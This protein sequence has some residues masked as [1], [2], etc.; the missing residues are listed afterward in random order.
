MLARWRDRDVVG[1]D[2]TAPQGRRAVG[3]LRGPAHGQ[4]PPRPPPRVGPRV[5]GPLPPLPDH[6][7][8]ATSPARAAGTA[9]G[10]RSRS[11]SR[12]SSGF[13]AKHEIEAYGIAEFNQRCRD[14]VQ[15]YVE[16]WAALTER[17]GMWI[18]TD[19]RLLDAV[20][21]T[22][23]NRSG[24]SSA[25]CGTRASLYEGHKVVALLRRAAAP[26]CR[27]TSSASQG[28]Q[29]VT[30]PSVYVRF[31]VVAGGPRRRPPRV[32]DHAVDAASP[33]SPPRSGPT[34][35]TCASAA[36]DGGRDLVLAEA[37]VERLLRR[38]PARSSRGSPAPTSSAGTTS[39]RST[40]LPLDDAGER[41]VA[42]DFVTTD[43]GSGIVHLAPA[44][45]EDD[46]EVGRRRG[47]PGAQP[48]RRRR[49]ASTRPV[50]PL[51]R[52]VREGRRPR[53][54]STTSPRAACSCAE[55][56]Y[57]HSYPHCWRCGTPLI[58]WAKT[59]VVRAHLRAARPSCCARTSASAGTP[60]TSSTAASATGSRTTSTGRCRATATGA[61]RSR[62]ALRRLRPR[63]VHRLG[64]RARR[65][66]AGR[67]L[68]RARPAPPV[69]RRR[70]LPLP[71]VRLRRRRARSR[72]CSTRGSTRARCRRRSSTT[73][74]RTRDAVR[75]AVPRR[76]HL[77]GHRPD[78]R[79][80]STR[81][82][83]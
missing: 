12:R 53:R 55:E 48:G 60:S 15:R 32:D 59:V 52:P 21:T 19:G 3:L 41:V 11:R 16:D 61:R 80:G 51:T 22:T 67:D 18:D 62:L 39:A 30:D 49:R 65:E 82:S 58:Y 73:R 72:R 50:P 2:R 34:S 69:R 70:H 4:R 54:S 29:D 57:A 64:R 24:G 20:A 74:S 47:P 7:R 13:T 78:A 14:S 46:R 1:G 71:A 56:P 17:S 42:A 9:T 44:F 77:R 35:T 10:C 68:G 5:Q 8:P 37:A 43:D 66:L 79:A 75:R 40:V 27:A 23:S 33:T 26:R 81:C 36:P 45:G 83:R 38:R 6:A 25:R 31:P 76:L 63:H 28:Y